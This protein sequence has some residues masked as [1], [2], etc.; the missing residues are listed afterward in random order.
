MLTKYILKK[1]GL[2]ARRFMCKAHTKLAVHRTLG[3][4]FLCYYVHNQPEKR[5]VESPALVK[6]LNPDLKHSKHIKPK[7]NLNKHA[8][9]AYTLSK[10][11]KQGIRSFQQVTF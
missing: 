2:C 10:N 9:L 4:Y 1:R 5:K 7:I 6:H 11:T 3:Q 8:I